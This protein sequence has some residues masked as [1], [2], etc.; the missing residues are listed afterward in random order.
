MS[1]ALSQYLNV[2]R[3]FHRYQEYIQHNVSS[4]KISMERVKMTVQ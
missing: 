3:A 2:C 1:P 4:H